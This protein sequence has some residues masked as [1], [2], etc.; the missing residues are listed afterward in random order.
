MHKL[1]MNNA[2]VMNENSGLVDHSQIAEF[3]ADSTIGIKEE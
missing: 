2:H 3:Q 1:K